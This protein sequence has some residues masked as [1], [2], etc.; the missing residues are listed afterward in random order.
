M[1][2]ILLEGINSNSMIEVTAEEL[3]Q[4]DSDE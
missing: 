1:D 4:K 2:K 3:K